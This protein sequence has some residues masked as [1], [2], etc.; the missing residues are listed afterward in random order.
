MEAA[1]V[2]QAL[3]GAARNCEQPRTLNYWITLSARS[4]SDCGIV[5]PSVF[6]AFR[7]TTA[8]AFH[9]EATAGRAMGHETTLAAACACQ[10]TLPEV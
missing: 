1:I 10:E 9:A 7:F 2:R 5:M 3:R 8:A 4:G 6:A